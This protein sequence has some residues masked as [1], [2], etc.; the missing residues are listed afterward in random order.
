MNH[1]RQRYPARSDRVQRQSVGDADV[2]SWP[3]RD[4]KAAHR[5]GFLFAALH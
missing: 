5:G 2:R 3:T 4:E 1:V